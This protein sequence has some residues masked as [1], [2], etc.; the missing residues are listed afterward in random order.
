MRAT[1]WDMTRAIQGWKRANGIKDD[2]DSNLS[3][4]E[5][6]ELKDFMAEIKAREKRNGKN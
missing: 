6:D 5:V 1:V 4:Y 3:R 2:P